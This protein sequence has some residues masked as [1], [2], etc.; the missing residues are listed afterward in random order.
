V[1]GQTGHCKVLGIKDAACAPIDATA[2]AISDCQAGYRCD[3]TTNKCVEFK[4]DRKRYPAGSSI[5][6]HRSRT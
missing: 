2:G 1:S 3:G 4:A 6:F 5:R